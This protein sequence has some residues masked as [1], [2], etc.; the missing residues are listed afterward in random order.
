MTREEL[1]LA[2]FLQATHQRA[3]DALDDLDPDRRSLTPVVSRL[4]T[5]YSA[6]SDG[7]LRLTGKLPSDVAF[8]ELSTETPATWARQHKGGR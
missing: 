1:N 2:Q 7:F 8:F 4:R 3:L 6:A 5:I